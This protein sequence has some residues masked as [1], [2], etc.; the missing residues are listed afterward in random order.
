MTTRSLN[1]HGKL[2]ARLQEN[3]MMCNSLVIKGKEIGAVRS[4]THLV[5]MKIL[6]KYYV[7]LDEVQTSDYDQLREISAHTQEVDA[8]RYESFLPSVV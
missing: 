5:L 7:V 3:D 1:G 2:C 6:S 8:L 4:Y